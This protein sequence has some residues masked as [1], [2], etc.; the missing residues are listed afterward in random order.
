MD[1]D[2][3]E[4]SHKELQQ[5]TERLGL[6]VDISEP[7]VTF[8]QAIMRRRR[9]DLWGAGA[10]AHSHLPFMPAAFDALLLHPAAMH[11]RSWEMSELLRVLRPGGTA[12]IPIRPWHNDI[13]RMPERSPSVP[14]LQSVADVCNQLRASG[15]TRIASE[16]ILAAT[17]AVVQ[18]F[19]GCTF[20]SGDELLRSRANA[21]RVLQKCCARASTSVNTHMVAQA[22]DLEALTLVTKTLIFSSYRWTEDEST[23]RGH[24]GLETPHGSDSDNVHVAAGIRARCPDLHLVFIN[25]CDSADICMKLHSEYGGRVAAIGWSSAILETDA[26]RFEAALFLELEAIKGFYSSDSE[27]LSLALD[28]AYAVLKE[29]A[30]PVYDLPHPA[31]HF[32]EELYPNLIAPSGPRPPSMT[33]RVASDRH[34]ALQGRAMTPPASGLSF[35]LDDPLTLNFNSGSR[36]GTLQTSTSTSSGPDRFMPQSVLPAEFELITAEV[37]QTIIADPNCLVDMWSP[38]VTNCKIIGSNEAFGNGELTLELQPEEV[39]VPLAVQDEDSPTKKKKKSKKKK[40]KKKKEEPEPDKGPR[41]R[42]APKDPPMQE[43][44]K[45][46]ADTPPTSPWFFAAGTKSICDLRHLRHAYPARASWYA[47]HTQDESTMYFEAHIDE[48][49]ADGGQV[50][51][52]LAGPGVKLH[53]QAPVAAGGGVVPTDELSAEKKLQLRVRALAEVERAAKEALEAEQAAKEPTG[54]VKVGGKPSAARGDPRGRKPSNAKTKKAKGE[55]L[56]EQ[57]DEEAP[58]TGVALWSCGAGGGMRCT[59]PHTV[60]RWGWAGAGVEEAAVRGPWKGRVRTAMQG[61]LPGDVIGIAVWRD[62]LASPPTAEVEF[63]KNGAPIAGVLTVQIDACVPLFPTFSGIGARV[64]LNF[65]RQPVFENPPPRLAYVI[66][67]PLAPPAEI[68][69]PPGESKEDREKRSKEE[70]LKE[71][72]KRAADAR[73]ESQAKGN[74]WRKPK[75]KK[76]SPKKSP[77]K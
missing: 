30:R 6:Y 21:A 71:A 9:E 55:K 70:R 45:P 69:E 60:G 25:A 42:A 49:A 33:V 31:W 40:K 3:V 7:M 72:R 27:N 59:A 4:M 65:G 36:P 17:D 62:R 1:V 2:V 61:V 56:D 19:F 15:F 46:G 57:P 64:R 44:E 5:E 29:G 43:A 48:L 26:T 53:E 32:P 34:L 10:D 58:P 24:F 8:Q 67:R 23:Y 66:P 35:N 76:K 28:R 74:D 18:G 37:P 14:V 52:G 54:P 11:I 47:M 68:E 51:V 77:P 20:G 13:E 39:V 12:S 63:S 75:K 41:K 50:L 16:P 38:G 73:A 22:G